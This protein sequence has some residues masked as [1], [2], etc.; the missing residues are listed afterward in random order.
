MQPTKI[1]RDRR[2][3]V[4]C[5]ASSRSSARPIPALSR[6]FGFPPVQPATLSGLSQ[7]TRDGPPHPGAPGLHRRAAQTGSARPA[8]LSPGRYGASGQPRWTPRRVPH[9]RRRHRH[10]MAG[11][12]LHPDHFRAASDS[13]AGSHVASVPFRI[14]GF[15]CDNGS[16]FLN[17]TVARLLN[18]LLV[19]FTKS[20][21]YRTTD[22]A[23]VEGKNGAVIR[24]HIGYGAIPAEHAEAFQKF[25]AAC[26]NPYL[27]HH[28]P[29][30]FA[31]LEWGARPA[32]PPLS[33]AGLLHS[34]RKADFAARLER[35]PQTGHHG[36]VAPPASLADQRHRRRPAHAEGQNCSASPLPV[37]PNFGSAG[38]LERWAGK[39]GSVA[40]PFPRTPIPGSHFLRKEASLA[41]SLPIFQAHLALESNPGFR[42]ISRL[43]NAWAFLC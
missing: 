2:Y 22:N 21:P 26:F 10:A 16:E 5:G 20:R 29:C 42:L 38:F 36:G 24:K 30:G 18:K 40:A 25:Y 6:H 27:N 43:E 34:L 17:Y 35:I 39:G 23:L 33:S 37:H 13:G 1:C 12:A 41:Q 9:Q 14:L 11:G 15:H 3:G 4:S 8:W 28:R 19:E 32:P 31:T 7:P